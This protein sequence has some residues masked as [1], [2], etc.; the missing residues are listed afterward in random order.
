VVANF[1]EHPPLGAMTRTW[2]TCNNQWLWYYPLVNELT[3]VMT[4]ME[5]LHKS[6]NNEAQIVEKA[7]QKFLQCAVKKFGWGH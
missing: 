2:E 3:G 6:E 1:N 4:K 5:H 7:H